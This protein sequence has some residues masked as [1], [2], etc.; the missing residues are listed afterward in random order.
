MPCTTI[1]GTLKIP[2]QYMMSHFITKKLAVWCVV[3]GWKI[4]GPTIFLRCGEFS[5]LYEQ[6]FGTIL[7]NTD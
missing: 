6:Y 2:T 1:T 4:N 7:L 5:A 3:T